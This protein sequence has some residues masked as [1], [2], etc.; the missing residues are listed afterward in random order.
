M[1][2]PGSRDKPQSVGSPLSGVRFADWSATVTWAKFRF[3]VLR[4]YVANILV[5]CKFQG[6]SEPHIEDIVGSFWIV[7]FDGC[8]ELFFRF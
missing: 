7:V 3:Q 1:S 4:F 6:Y 8:S 5:R 2:L